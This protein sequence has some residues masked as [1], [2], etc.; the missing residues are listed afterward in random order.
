MRAILLDPSQGDVSVEAEVGLYLA[1]RAQLIQEVV[2]PAL[3]RG[4]DVVCERWTLSTEVYQGVAGGFGAQRVRRA[5]RALLPAVRPDRVILLDV[6]VGAGLKRLGRAP[7]RMEQ[8][9]DAFHASVVRAYRR[10][11]RENAR[12][13]V[14]PPGTPDA[15][16]AR[17]LI[18]VGRIHV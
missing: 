4:A 17:I 8:K 15:V 16:H 12:H 18:A 2:A 9:G 10:L 3:R 1:A 11:A 14:I 7:D 5:A 13:T 6:A